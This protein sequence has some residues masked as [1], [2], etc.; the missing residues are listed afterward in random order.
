MFKTMNNSFSSYDGKFDST[1]SIVTMIFYFITLSS[2]PLF[3]SVALCS[4]SFA[5]FGFCCMLII[6]VL[7]FKNINHRNIGLF[8]VVIAFCLLI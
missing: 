6:I 5:G 2:P 4:S 3:S 7:L 8:K 1:D